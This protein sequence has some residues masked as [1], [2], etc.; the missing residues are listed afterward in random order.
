VSDKMSRR[1]RA[2]HSG[3]D[4]RRRRETHLG[5]TLSL[6]PHCTSRH[7]NV[8]ALGS[9]AEAGLVSTTRVIRGDRS[10]EYLWFLGRAKKS[11]AVRAAI[12]C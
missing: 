1:R 7:S 5:G 9:V 10:G 6:R 4:A 8:P 12:A 2:S 11:S 3:N